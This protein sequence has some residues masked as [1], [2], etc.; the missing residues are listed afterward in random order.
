MNFNWYGNLFNRDVLIN[1]FRNQGNSF[2]VEAGYSHAL[3]DQ[4]LDLRLKLAG[5]QFDVGDKVSGWRGGAD[6]TTRDGV[7]TLRYEYGRDRLNGDYNTVGGFVTVG[8]QLEN[9]LKG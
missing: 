9:I 3:F 7:F 4:S 2:D 6:L 5:Y 1:A 8:L